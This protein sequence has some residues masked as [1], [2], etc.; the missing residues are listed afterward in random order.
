MK[1]TKQ[2]SI[3]FFFILISSNILKAEQ[4]IAYLNLDFILQNSIKGKSIYNELE[5]MNEINRNKISTKENKL[6]A[7]ENE[8]IKQ[9]NIL[10]EVDF[11]KKV[12]DLRKK[13]NEFNQEKKKLS[14]E[15]EKQKKTKLNN[16]LEKIVPIIENYV[17]DNSIGLVLNQKNVFIGSK[18]YDITNDILKIIDVKIKWIT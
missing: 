17:K 13:I 1:L 12:I 8:I 14:S 4:Q 9:K 7:E 10:S 16:F 2:I 3:I 11:E 18:K 5:K 6:R 15:Y